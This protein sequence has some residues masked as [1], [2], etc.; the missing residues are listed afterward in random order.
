MQLEPFATRYVEPS[1]R[2]S[3]VY[4]WGNVTRILALLYAA[5]RGG[6]RRLTTGRSRLEWRGRK[7]CDGERIQFG[8][9]CEWGANVRNLGRPLGL[10]LGEPLRATVTFGCGH[11]IWLAAPLLSVILSRSRLFQ[12]NKS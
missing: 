1:V 8:G 12:E 3:V 2:G 10:K 7:L 9:P 4:G 5:A 11:R 6:A